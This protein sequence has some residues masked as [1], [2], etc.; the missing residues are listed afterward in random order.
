MTQATAAHAPART[1]TGRRPNQP[2][3]HT[4]DAILAAARHEFAVRGYAGA[5]VDRIAAAAHLNK[6]MI[7]Y[8]FASKSGLY[9]AMLCEMFERAGDEMRAIVAADSAPEAKLDAIVAVITARVHAHRELPSI[10]MRE[11]AEGARHLDPEMLRAMSVLFQSVAAV[12]AEGQQRG[13][14][15]NLNPL[16]VY[17]TLVGPL[18]LFLGA[19]PVRTAMGRLLGKG[20]WDCSEEELRRHLQQVLRR[21]LVRPQAPQSDRVS[22]RSHTRHR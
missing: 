8:H 9:H 12:V 19:A 22:P 7:Y 16:L 20:G 13:R 6:A 5:R 11:V 10:M 14:F 1:R 21:T 17:F 15:D 18:I 4:R 3:G 2:A